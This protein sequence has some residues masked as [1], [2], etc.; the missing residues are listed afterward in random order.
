M[1]SSQA[2]AMVARIAAR[3]RYF[4]PI[5]DALLRGRIRAPCKAVQSTDRMRLQMGEQGDITVGDGLPTVV[6]V[7]PPPGWGERPRAYHGRCH[8]STSKRSRS[9]AREA[10]WIDEHDGV[11]RET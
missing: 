8:L 4:A 10:R 9:V 11:R 6:T 2:T 3:V 5:A 1:P 7:V